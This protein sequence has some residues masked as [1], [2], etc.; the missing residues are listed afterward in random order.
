[1]KILSWRIDGFGVFTGTQVNDIGPGLTIVHGRNESGKTTLVDFLCG[2]LFGY[3]DRRRRL[4]QHEPLA[5]GRHGGS[6]DLLGDDGTR[7]RVERHV[8]TREAIITSDGSPRSGADLRRVLGGADEG[9]F[10]S[11]FAFGLD[12]LRSLDTL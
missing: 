3:P 2:V 4:A 9:L 7:M 12:E 1:M 10:R 5:G 8:G 6:V 11:T